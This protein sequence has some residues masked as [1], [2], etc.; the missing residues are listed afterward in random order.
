MASDLAICIDS[1]EEQAPNG[2]L[3]QL[4]LPQPKSESRRA[5]GDVSIV[6]VQSS[7]QTELSIS[8]A[9][10]EDGRVTVPT[11]VVSHMTVNSATI[12]LKL[13]EPMSWKVSPEDGLLED[14]ALVPKETELPS[15][16]STLRWWLPHVV[17]QGELPQQLGVDPVVLRYEGI[18]LT[19]RDVELLADEQCLNDSVLDF[20]LKLAVDTVAPEH[21]KGDLYVAST[22]FFQKLTSGG[23]ENGEA[24]WQNVR[25]WTRALP[26]G[27]LGQ[28]FV[29]I[30][31]NEQNIHWW[32]AVICHARRAL[33]PDGETMLGEAPRIVCL[34]SAIE[35]L[36][37]GRVVAFLR[38]Y[39]WKEWCERHPNATA[40]D[41]DKVAG[42]L[43]LKALAADVPKQANSFDCGIFIIEYLLHLLRSKTALAGLGL[44]AHKHWFGQASVSHRRKRLK[45][46]ATLLQSQAQRFGETDVRR[47]L[48]DPRL[49]AAVVLAL[50]DHPKKASPSTAPKLKRPSEAASER[51]K[52][53]RP[54]CTEGLAP[55][56]AGRVDKRGRL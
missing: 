19:A 1:D 37:K 43:N 42:Q 40:F 48:Q 30:P 4:L 36:L 20:F 28:R 46:L 44:A 50:T 47:L 14:F 34:D 12:V 2:L 45:W 13:Q 17:V 35:P 56:R 52:K 6:Q 3:C 54:G 33:E 29:V 10:D 8:W 9:E 38:G 7:G 51:K 18:S 27:L 26:G 23:V 11:R 15:V 32:L 41:E 22:F 53:P 31:I 5:V 16:L 55:S 49:R 25:R 24:G 39:L 21:L